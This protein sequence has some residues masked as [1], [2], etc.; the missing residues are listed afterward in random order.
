MQEDIEYKIGDV[1]VL[2]SGGP[3]MTV[4]AI[5]AAS[6]LS[7]LWFNE[8]GSISN[9]TFSPAMVTKKKCSDCGSPERDLRTPKKEYSPKG[10][11]V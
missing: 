2:N 9:G 8:A 6:G 4:K 7:C 3:A 5:G 1:V 11:V 10:Q